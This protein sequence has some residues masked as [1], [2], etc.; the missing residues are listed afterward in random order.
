MRSKKYLGR[1]LGFL[2]VV[3]LTAG[4]ARDGGQQSGPVTDSTG[5][6]AGNMQNSP[7]G[8]SDADVASVSESVPDVA[9]VPVSEAEDAE[10]AGKQLYLREY[11]R[12]P[13]KVSVPAWEYPNKVVYA[14]VF[15]GVVYILAEYRSGEGEDLS[16]QFF[17]T[18]YRS[19]ATELIWEPF[20]LD[21]PE[22][23]EW[24]IQSIAMPEEG[25]L[26]FRVRVYGSGNGEV[27]EA[28]DSDFLAVT[29]LK[30]KLLSMT[31]PFPEE[32]EYLWNPAGARFGDLIGRG[33]DGSMAISKRNQEGYTAFYSYDPE[34]GRR[35]EI[36]VSA[37][38]SQ[39]EAIYPEGNMLYYVDSTRHLFRWDD[40]EKKL[41]EL[42]D[43]A[44][45]N[46]PSGPDLFAFL[47]PGGAGRLL[48]CS[49]STEMFQIFA[50]SEEE[51][52]PEDGIRMSVL[53]D[54]HINYQLDTA[55]EYNFAHWNCP[56]STEEAE[57]NEED[58]FRNRIMAQIVAGKGPDLM[59]VSAEDMVILAEKGALLDLTELIPEETMEQLFPCV[60]QDGTVDGKMVGLTTELMIDTMITADSTWSGESWTLEEFLQLSE[61]HEWELPIREYLV[62]ID[63]MRCLKA[64][65]PDLGHSQFL[66]MEA[67]IARFDSDEF[68]KILEI[69]KKYEGR[70]QKDVELGMDGLLA[71]EY[72][73]RQ[74][75]IMRL[76]DFSEF[77]SEY[78]GKAHLVGYPAEGGGHFTWTNFSYLVVNANTEHKEEIKKYI[79]MLLDYDR[80]MSPNGFLGI[81]VRRDV[82]RDSVVTIDGIPKEIIGG[83]TSLQDLEYLKP[84]GTSY[85]EEFLDFID[86]CKAGGKWPSQIEQILEE[87]LA[88]YFQGDKS[89]QEVA[90]LVQNRVQLYLN[91][92]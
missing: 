42:M 91:E 75:W 21:F 14:D 55:V 25:E 16:R 64:L 82:V 20:A 38:V 63:S 46:F 66:D 47:L 24:V 36:G 13:I 59:L 30:G 29:D 8:S 43:L 85:M 53:R 32:E 11:T 80:Q 3:V 88:P 22:K 27:A 26:S 68:I 87:D 62:Y 72:A 4:C 58:A 78:S 74:R 71:Q 84:D 89:A 77:L 86:G 23:S 57:R 70:E 83:G 73:A 39:V 12:L 65:L 69:C 79:E 41:T 45:I 52:H 40:K 1:F 76:N 61:E 28:V 92:R 35:D 6:P 48:L 49:L 31:D 81:S 17:L 9:P 7:D 2:L 37:E 51:Y 50:L 15:D 34:T 18:T 19:G 60:I 90:A 33:A 56:I 67:G 44:E 10:I 54:S 5:T